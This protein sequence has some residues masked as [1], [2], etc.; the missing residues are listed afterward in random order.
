MLRKLP[1]LVALWV[2][3]E[4]SVFILIIILI[5]YGVAVCRL[6]DY[7]IK[8]ARDESLKCHLLQCDC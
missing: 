1:S 3:D 4:V 6:F 2:A 5:L 7:G 8:D